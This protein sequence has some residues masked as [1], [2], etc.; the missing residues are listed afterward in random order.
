MHVPGPPRFGGTLSEAD[1]K[2][3]AL[4]CRREM[5]SHVKE[6]DPVVRLSISLAPFHVLRVTSK[7]LEVPRSGPHIRYTNIIARYRDR[8]VDVELERVLPKEELEI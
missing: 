8:R 7:E 5:A 1:I 3:V 2:P 4:Y 6:P